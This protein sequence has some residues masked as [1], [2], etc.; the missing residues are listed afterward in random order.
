MKNRM[1]NILKKS[2]L[3]SYINAEIKC[4]QLK[5]K[6]K[7]IVNKYKNIKQQYTFEE[8][9]VKK[10]FSQEWKD[11]LQNKKLNIYFIGTDEF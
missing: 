9:L 5:S 10:G 6:Y 7:N 1:K 8:L 4:K 3:I 11:S 2:K